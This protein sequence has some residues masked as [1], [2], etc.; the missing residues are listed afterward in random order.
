GARP[1]QEST[2]PADA[3]D[4]R[5][6][7]HH[8]AVPPGHV[9]DDRQYDSR[10]RWRRVGGLVDAEEYKQ[11]EREAYNKVATAWAANMAGPMAVYGR[12]LLELLAPAPGMRLLDLACGAGHLVVDA[13]LHYHC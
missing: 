11:F 6:Q 9:L 13:A 7:V 3:P 10:G 4:R 12:R 1:R 8:R 5:R 2:P